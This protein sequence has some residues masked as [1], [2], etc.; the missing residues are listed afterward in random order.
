MKTTQ[1]ASP[2]YPPKSST[3]AALDATLTLHQFR[4]CQPRTFSPGKRFFKPARTLY[5]N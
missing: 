5:I 4:M 2:E 3:P 1:E